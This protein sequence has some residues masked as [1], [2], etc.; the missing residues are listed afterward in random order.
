[1]SILPTVLP[2]LRGSW[3]ILSRL[4]W[5][6]ALG[7]AL[8][9][10]VGATWFE[11]R[12]AS[13]STSPLWVEL[14][15]TFALGVRIFPPEISKTWVI[16]KTFSREAL[17]S[18]IR[19]GDAILAVNGRAV[20]R[21]TTVPAFG[22]L[23]DSREGQ[24]VVLRL[25]STDGVV[26]DHVLIHSAR[27]V[28]AWYGGSGLD[29]KRQ[30]LFRRIGYDLMTLLL[31]L[32]STILFVRRSHDIVAVA[33]SLSLCL[34]SIGS[35]VEF[36]NAISAN[37]LYNVLA[38]CPYILWLMVG[39]AFPD[40]HYW[41]S[42]TRFSLVIVPLML[43][44][45]IFFAA[46]YSQF[47]I[48]TAPGFIAMI[49]VLA[50]RYRRLPSGI[51][52]QQFRWVAFGL[53]MGTFMLLGRLA[54]AQ[55]QVRLD[56]APLSPWI[57]LAGSFLHAFSY[58]IIGAGFGISLL[59]YR[60]YDAE[61]LI[62]R[63]AALTAATLMLAGLWAACE[64]A[65]ETSLPAF[66]GG[67]QRALT[68]ILSAAF[69]V[70]LVS[71]VHGGVHEWIGKRFQ[72]GVYRLKE[73]LPTLVDALALRLDL[74]ELCERVLAHVARDVRATKAAIVVQG[75][76]GFFVAARHRVD[77]AD[78][79]AWLE[80]QAAA[81][82]NETADSSFN[83]AIRL[84]DTLKD[85]Q[86][87]WLLVGPRPDGTSCNRDEREALKEVAEPIARAIA[88]VQARENRDARLVTALQRLESRMSAVEALLPVEQ[89]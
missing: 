23:L 22:Q 79:H 44:P 7:I 83:V 55:F 65:I 74:S 6:A 21:L 25:R 66:A 18:G 57:D 47:A 71:V 42:W 16:S 14:E 34:M 17:A 52:R 88:A 20:T 43:I 85:E 82:E 27:N 28:K 61:S 32:P 49:A 9:S 2:R 45:A 87:G 69:A 1:M 62:S 39:W 10:A 89:T 58:A 73:K 48:F 60:L 37:G 68:E 59:K 35:A 30:F 70:I 54:F 50:L 31:L 78:V 19:A 86:I 77:D 26:R 80:T 84:A 3:L 8:F 63:S 5:F 41:P 46:D 36:W 51:E 38:D 24:K 81:S 13:S 15:R 40:G 76:N 75:R 33:F 12:D 29:A 67:E 4:L 11:T 64:K 56:P 72:R 53:A